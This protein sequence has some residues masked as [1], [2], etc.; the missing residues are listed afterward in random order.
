MWYNVVVL[1]TNL[2]TKMRFSHSS[3]LLSLKYNYYKMKIKVTVYVD[4]L[5]LGKLE[6]E[7]FEQG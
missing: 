1:K 4:T 3:V 7:W 6:S 5:V 2:T